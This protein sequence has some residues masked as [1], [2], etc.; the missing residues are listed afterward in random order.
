MR[1]AQIDDFFSDI[2]E[3]N[4]L[5][6]VIAYRQEKTERERWV[7]SLIFLLL[8]TAA[9]V[10]VLLRLILGIAIIKGSSMEPAFK[11]RDVVL[12][13]R[14]LDKYR[15][16]DVVLIETGNTGEDYFKRIVGL[17]GQ[18]V[19]I[20]SV[21]GEVLIDG[22]PLEEPYIYSGT[23]KNGGLDY[24]VSLGADEYFVLGDNRAHSKDSRIFGPVKQNEIDG[25]V[26]FV[27]RAYR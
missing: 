20:D 25:K 17:P 4:D 15:T 6:E 1:R 16:G 22:E 5:N 18:T 24:P 8:I 9:A 7:R 23:E 12:F 13:A 3:N 19:D 2:T 14:I 11:E 21:N 10:I 27:I 26:F